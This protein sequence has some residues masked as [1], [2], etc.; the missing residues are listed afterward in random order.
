[1]KYVIHYDV[2]GVIILATVMLHFFYK[3]TINTRQT[4]AFSFLIW[5]AFISNALDLITIYTIEHS[6]HV[7]LFLNYLLNEAY[8]IAFNAI[9]VI[10]FIYILLTIKSR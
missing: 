5:T 10:Y 6:G 3:K 4:R 1:M 9:P 2:A 8:L 7:N